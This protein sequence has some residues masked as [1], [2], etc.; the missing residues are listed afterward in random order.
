MA[1]T[2]RI[3]LVQFHNGLITA[4]ATRNGQ[5]QDDA[6]I[7]LPRFLRFRLAPGENVQAPVRSAQSQRCQIKGTR[8]TTNRRQR[9]GFIILKVNLAVGSQV[10]VPLQSSKAHE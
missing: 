10:K 7:R 9:G 1:F 2:T 5:I 6:I 8:S 3:D 4:H